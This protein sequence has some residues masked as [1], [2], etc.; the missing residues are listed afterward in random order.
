[1]KLKKKEISQIKERY[2]LERFQYIE[3][4]EG[5][6]F[7]L[8]FDDDVYYIKFGS[9]S[10]Y[11]QDDETNMKIYIEGHT[12]TQYR[13]RVTFNKIVGIFNSNSWNYRSEKRE[14][15]LRCNMKKLNLKEFLEE[16]KP[17]F[18]RDVTISQL[19]D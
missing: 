5:D 19:V 1:M 9:Y 8:D 17:G 6:T 3:F 7:S 15:T 2:R 14:K 12:S 16:H 4:E 10:I 13:L 18:K 11:K